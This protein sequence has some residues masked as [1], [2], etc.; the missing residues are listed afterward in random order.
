MP[1]YIVT[2][3]LP[4]L[5]P[6]QLDEIGRKVVAVCSEMP[7]V[8]WIRSH[9]TV[10]GKHSFCELEAPNSEACREHARRAGLPVDEVVPLGMEIGPGMFK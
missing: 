3:T 4:P 6:D 5:T 7:G 8:E 2:R 1:R 10:D 9:L